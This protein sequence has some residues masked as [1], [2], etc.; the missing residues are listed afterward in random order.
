MKLRI[1]KILLKKEIQLMKRNPFI[2]RVI[3]AM[4]FVAML[5]LPLVANLDVKNVSV[6]VV[7]NDHSELS[8]RIVTDMDASEY[9]SVQ[10]CDFLYDEALQSV[11]NGDAD[12]ILVIPADYSDNLTKGKIRS[13]RLM[14]TGST[15]QKGCSVPGM[16]RSPQPPLLRNGYLKQA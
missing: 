16:R 13:C 3:V 8:R 5:V 11:E 14:P 10:S 12:A 7:D 1:L 4:P 2:P 6:A 9:L 15:H